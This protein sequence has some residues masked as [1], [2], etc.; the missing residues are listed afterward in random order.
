MLY[1]QIA[2]VAVRGYKIRKLIKRIILQGIITIRF[3]NI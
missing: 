3:I 1:I 2:I